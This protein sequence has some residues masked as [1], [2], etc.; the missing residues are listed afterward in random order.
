M[1]TFSMDALS[2]RGMHKHRHL[3]TLRCRREGASTPSLIPLCRFPKPALTFALAS[4]ESTF[5]TSGCR[6][7]TMSVLE[8]DAFVRRMGWRGTATPSRG[9]RHAR[10][11]KSNC[12]RHPSCGDLRVHIGAVGPN[13]TKF[14]MDED[15]PVKEISMI[16]GNR[17]CNLWPRSEF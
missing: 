11:S 13:V 16:T 12:S 2:I 6:I 5:S 9:R 15:R 3:G 1:L 17:G 7:D 8:T 14:F 4:D 10:F